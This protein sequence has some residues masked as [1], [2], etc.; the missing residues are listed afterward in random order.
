MK[1]TVE[2][3]LHASRR[4]TKQEGVLPA[5]ALLRGFMAQVADSSMPRRFERGYTLAEILVALMIGGLLLAAGTTTTVAW[6]G[7]EES[8]SAVYLLQTL[9]QSARMQAISRHRSCQI[10]LDTSTRLIQ[11][12]DLNDPSNATDDVTVTSVTLSPRLSFARPDGSTPVTLSL[13]SGTTYQTTF[14]SDG[15][16]TQGS[17]VITVF[18]GDRYEQLTVYGA[19]GVRLDRWNGSAWQVG[20]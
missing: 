4:E 12:I 2:R 7:R 9:V 15:A 17:G 8:R 11:V 10:K 1:P 18:G 5:A 3:A 20:S 13:V 19:G 6:I 14:G 16:V